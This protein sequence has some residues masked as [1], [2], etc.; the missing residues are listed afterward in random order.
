MRE[1]VKKQKIQKK[2]EIHFFSKKKY[3]F[4]FFVI[5][6][7]SWKTDKSDQKLAKVLATYVYVILK[8]FGKK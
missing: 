5:L 8:N 6:I 4:D 2:K 7:F 1:N 3:F